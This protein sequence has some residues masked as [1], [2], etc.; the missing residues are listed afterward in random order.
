M[1]SNAAFASVFKITVEN[2]ATVKLLPE[3]TT[4]NLRNSAND[5]DRYR[6]AAAGA[7]VSAANVYAINKVIE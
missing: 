1:N 7:S 3:T 6:F 2:A 5:R 4:K